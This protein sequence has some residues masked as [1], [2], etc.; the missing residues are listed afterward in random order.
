M[1]RLTLQ[2]QLR[3]YI[4]WCNDHSLEAKDAKNLIAYFREIRE[5]AAQA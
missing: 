5:M 3:F 4:Q 2:E 1:E